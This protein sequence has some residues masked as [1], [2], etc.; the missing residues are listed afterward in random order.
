MLLTS[1]LIAANELSSIIH[2]S[3][4]VVHTSV[5]DVHTSVSSCTH[6]LFSWSHVTHPLQLLTYVF[7]VG[8]VWSSVVHMWFLIASSIIFQMPTC[9]LLLLTRDFLVFTRVF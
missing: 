6:V 1:F 2:I 8:H 3:V 9:G 5:S 7:L 4:L